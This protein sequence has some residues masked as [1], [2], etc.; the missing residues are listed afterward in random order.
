MTVD[1]ADLTAADHLDAAREM[2]AAGPPL[3]RAPARRGSRP[4][5]RRPGHRSPS[6]R[7]RFPDPTCPKET[8]LT[9]PPATTST[10]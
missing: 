5:H 4:P 1:P 7:A 9:C 10:P 8:D 2:A 6:I 3:P